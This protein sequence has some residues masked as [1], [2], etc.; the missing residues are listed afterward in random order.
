MAR[1][2]CRRAKPKFSAGDVSLSELYHLLTT[3]SS[4][5]MAAVK[6]PSQDPGSEEERK[7]LENF[8]RRY[9]DNEIQGHAAVSQPAS[10]SPRP[11]S[12]GRP[13]LCHLWLRL[14]SPPPWYLIQPPDHRG[15]IR[16]PLPQPTS[17]QLHPT[18]PM[19]NGQTVRTHRP[20]RLLF[21]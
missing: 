21:P 10:C 2:G 16:H 9:A 11:L 15:Q 6:R 13:V 4:D 14:H 12:T 3:F 5:V 18:E 8:L 17:F 19:Y 7:A 20:P 1:C